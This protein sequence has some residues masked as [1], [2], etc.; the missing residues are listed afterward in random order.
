MIELVRDLRAINVAKFENDLWKIMD[1]RVL[2]GL[3]CPPAGRPARPPTRGTTIPR[4]PEGL[5]GKNWPW[6]SKFKI[7]GEVKVKGHNVSLTSYQLTSLWFH[8]NWPSHSW[9]TS[10]S[11]F[12]LENPRSRSYL[13]VTKKVYHPF[14][15][16]PFRSMSIG[17]PIPG[18]QLF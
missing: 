5:R 4:S 18:I 9:D 14:D 8:V 2:T 3:V 11:K 6:K 10:F 16:Y 17:P 7:M 13:K 15:S 1:M 12:D